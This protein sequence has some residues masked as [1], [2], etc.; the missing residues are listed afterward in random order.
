[1][2][3]YVTNWG[4]T[5][6]ASP[7]PNSGTVGKQQ[8][9]GKTP[10]GQAAGTPLN[11]GSQGNTFQKMGGAASQAVR[12][13]SKKQ[14]AGAGALAAVGEAM[15]AIPRAKDEIDAINADETMSK[16]EKA[17]A[18]GGAVGDA[19]GSVAGAAIGGIG[20]LAAGAAAGAAIGS[21]VPGLGTAAGLIVGGLVGLIGT[22]LGGM[23]GRAI[24]EE[25]GSAVAGDDEEKQP[26]KLET[27]L[28][29]LQTIQMPSMP[30]PIP[31]QN[32]P[33]EITNQYMTDEPKWQGMNMN[34]EL[35]GAADVNLHVTLDD[36]RTMLSAETSRNTARNIRVNTG[37]AV[38]ARNM[39]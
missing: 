14:F 38:E 27:E 29:N 32:L 33:P 24:G 37:S 23:A 28:P 2:P 7:L 9:V 34:A 39:L 31:A 5:A 11:A 16:K 6:G 15:I 26:K 18:K 25:I 21:I 10:T 4:G 35:S 22:K 1:M 8:P 19:A 17:T 12:G 30:L 3:V 13:I 36:N 20:G